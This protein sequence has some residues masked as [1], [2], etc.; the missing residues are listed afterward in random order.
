MVLAACSFGLNFQPF[1]LLARLLACLVACVRMQLRHRL[2]VLAEAHALAGS[3]AMFYEIDLNANP[4]VKTAIKKYVS[5]RQLPP[6]VTANLY[7]MQAMF[8]PRSYKLYA[9][10]E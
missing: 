7:R 6:Y 9:N 2:R 1:V 5:V 8:S 4:E 3:G 10:P